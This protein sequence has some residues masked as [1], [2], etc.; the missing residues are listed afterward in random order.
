MI[1]TGR[2]VTTQTRGLTPILISIDARLEHAPSS[3]ITTPPSV[4]CKAQGR[5]S[6]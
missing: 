5:G 2:C 6:N 1:L 4:N 3:L